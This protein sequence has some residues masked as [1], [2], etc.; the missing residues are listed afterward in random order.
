MQLIKTI[1]ANPGC[2]LN[3]SCDQRKQERSVL[4]CSPGLT[5]ATCERGP[6][7]MC[8]SV[9]AAPVGDAATGTM[10]VR[11]ERGPS[12]SWTGPEAARKVATC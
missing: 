1:P 3:L 6:T 8:A 11:A 12:A 2:D 10:D 9:A 7:A 5:A 4:S